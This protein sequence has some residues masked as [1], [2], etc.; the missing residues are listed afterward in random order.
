MKRILLFS[1]VLLCLSGIHSQAQILSSQWNGAKVA[2]LGDSITDANQLKTQDIYWHQLVPILGIEPFCYGISGHQT[3][4]ILGQAEKLL[5]EHGQ[6]VDAILI[7]IGTNDFNSSIPLGEWFR[8]E[9]VTVNRNGRPAT[10]R[11]RI[12]DRD[13]DTMRARINRFMSFLK[14]HYPTKQVILL[15][16]IHRGYFNCHQYNVQPEESFANPLGLYID[17]YIRVIKETA[18]VWAVPVIDLAAICGLYPMEPE[19]AR[20]FREADAPRAHTAV[21]AAAAKSGTELALEHHDL[22][23]PNTE[24]QLRMA[25]AL[26][27]QLLG[28]PARF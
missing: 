6:D 24:G 7:F 28:Y 16:P 8:E 12:P 4:H 20:Y 23:H 1:L 18:D 17:D 13:S 5:S 14:H 3:S 9:A 22:L 21:E 2:F 27:Y 19:Q 25:W 11:H 15:T 10:L 26:A